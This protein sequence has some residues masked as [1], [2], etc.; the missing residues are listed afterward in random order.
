MS[1]TA[2]VEGRTVYEDYGAFASTT[3]IITMEVTAVTRTFTW[4]ETQNFSH[5]MI[6]I[7]SISVLNKF[8]Q[9]WIRKEWLLSLTNSTLNSVNL[10]FMPGHTGFFF[11]HQL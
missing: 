1:I 6:L 2:T 5:A 9:V 7:N 3:R 4:L 8:E 10:I 11:V